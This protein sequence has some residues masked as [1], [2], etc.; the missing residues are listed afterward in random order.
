MMAMKPSQ[1]LLDTF[2]SNKYSRLDLV[3]TRITH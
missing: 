1:G 3:F 2:K